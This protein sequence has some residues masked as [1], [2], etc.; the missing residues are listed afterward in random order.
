MIGLELRPFTTLPE[1]ADVRMGQGACE[2]RERPRQNPF[3]EWRATVQLLIGSRIITVS[4][5][6]G[7]PRGRERNERDLE[8]EKVSHSVKLT[9]IVWNYIVGMQS[10]APWR[11]RNVSLSFRVKSVSLEPLDEYWSRAGFSRKARRHLDGSPA[12]IDLASVHMMT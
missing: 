10:V 4:M 9:D 7:S 12:H 3:G 8:K 1:R 5:G 6:R 11:I 2:E